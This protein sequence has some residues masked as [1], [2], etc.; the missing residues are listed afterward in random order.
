VRA[1]PVDFEEAAALWE[2]VQEFVRRE[3]LRP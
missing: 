2:E 1:L 3:F